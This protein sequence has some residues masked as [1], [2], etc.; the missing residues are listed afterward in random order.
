MN[1]KF[2]WDDLKAASNKKK[3]GISFEEA[4][5]VFGDPLARI[6][7]DELHSSG[8][9]QREIIIG[10]SLNNH[11][12]LVCFTERGN[13]IRIISARKTT[14]RERKDYEKNTQFRN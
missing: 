4:T 9:E 12:L 6:F 13:S 7:D 5:T 10:H 3:H 14:K 1:L 11:L 2:E 8:M